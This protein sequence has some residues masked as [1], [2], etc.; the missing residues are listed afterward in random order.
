MIDLEKS[1]IS[2]IRNPL[3]LGDQ[4]F[5]K[6]SKV[7][8]TAYMIARNTDNNTFYLN[9]CINEDQFNQLYDLEWQIKG[10]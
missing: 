3:N 1:P 9:N 5:Y 6:I 4:Q 2:S 8:Q 7:L 10:T